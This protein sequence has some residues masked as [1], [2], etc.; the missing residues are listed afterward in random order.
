ML[1]E[2]SVHSCTL[3]SVLM[4][5]SS[6][7]LYLNPQS[8]QELRDEVVTAPV[9]PVLSVTTRKASLFALRI[10]SSSLSSLILLPGLH[11]LMFKTSHFYQKLAVFIPFLQNFFPLVCFLHLN[12]FGPE[13]GPL[14]RFCLLFLFICMMLKIFFKTLSG[15]FSAI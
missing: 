15:F 10:S 2:F 14:A 1:P 4:H 5:A 11:S 12:Y 13:M 8:G 6:P 7:H 3:G 9:L